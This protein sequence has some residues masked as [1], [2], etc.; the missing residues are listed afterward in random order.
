MNNIRC[1]LKKRERFEK[2][3]HRI[4]PKACEMIFAYQV[5]RKEKQKLK[6][7]VIA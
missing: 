6:W 3:P 5:S 1:N 4:A 7:P 2:R